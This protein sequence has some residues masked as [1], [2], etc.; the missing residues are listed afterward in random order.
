M[1]EWK[2]GTVYSAGLGLGLAFMSGVCSANEHFIHVP[3][4]TFEW[5]VVFISSVLAL[6]FNLTK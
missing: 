1:H 2:M 5:L 6:F 3:L 4:A